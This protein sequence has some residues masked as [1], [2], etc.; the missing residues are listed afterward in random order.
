MDN[1][2]EQETR[3]VVERKIETDQ[4]RSQLMTS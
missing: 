2:L 4:L 1:D 3:R